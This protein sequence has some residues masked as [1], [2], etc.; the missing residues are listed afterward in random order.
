VIRDTVWCC[1]ALIDNKVDMLPY[2]DILP[3]CGMS[4]CHPTPLDQNTLQHREGDVIAKP[5]RTGLDGLR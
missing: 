2:C 4:H 5:D 3:Y 1:N